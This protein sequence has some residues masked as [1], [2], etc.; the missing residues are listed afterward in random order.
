MINEE[1]DTERRAEA[2][3]LLLMTVALIGVQII[4]AC[5]A[6]PFLPQRIPIHWNIA[7]QVD[8]YATKLS[9]LF[10]LPGTSFL[11]LVLSRS[12]TMLDARRARENQQV[13]RRFT[14]YVIAAV[15][16]FLLVLQLIIIATALHYPLNTMLIAAV[17]V[18]LLLIGIGNYLGKL[19]PNRW[20]GIRTRWTLANDTVWERTHR[21]GGWLFVAA[22]MVGLITAFLPG[23]GVWGILVALFVVVI[24]VTT[25][26]YV[27]YRR[28]VARGGDSHSI[29]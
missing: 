3:R 7:G 27:E 9:G 28:I 29:M 13:A 10:I 26:S 15:M 20:A 14:D 2:R 5:I 8:G 16:L 23:V 6:Y 17:M 21:L 4:I 19:R 12:I 11:L 24:I 18:S 1:K 22:G 25:Y